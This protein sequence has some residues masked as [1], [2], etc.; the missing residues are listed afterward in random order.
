MLNKIARAAL[1]RQSLLLRELVLELLHTYPN[2]NVVPEEIFDT[3]SHQI[4]ATAIL[5]LLA[6]RRE[7]KT[8]I[9]AQTTNVLPAP[10]YLLESALTMPRLKK[11]CETQSPMPLRKRGLLAPPQFLEFA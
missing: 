5:E 9:W 10:F 8:P 1:N 7:Q 3:P 6:E 11:L 2:L 4:T